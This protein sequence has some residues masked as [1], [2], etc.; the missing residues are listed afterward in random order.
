M[1]TIVE[2]IVAPGLKGAARQYFNVDEF[3]FF[4]PRVKLQSQDRSRTREFDVIAYTPEYF[5][6]VETK[7]SP[8]T[9]DVSDFTKLLPEIPQWFPRET[10]T[11]K[12][13]PVFASL[14]LDENIISFLTNNKIL[15]MAT[16]DDS[17][18]LYNPQI[19]EILS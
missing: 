11:R 10:E 8:D 7:S 4:A 12:L 17:M 5:F 16:R 1:G 6:V 2:D 13:I 14:Y 9:R 18:D 15:A 19:I 3:T